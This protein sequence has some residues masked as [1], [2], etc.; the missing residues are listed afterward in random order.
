MILRVR[1]VSTGNVLDTVT[2]DGDAVAY[3]TGAARSIV[4]SRA[5]ARSRGSSPAEACTALCGWSNGYLIFEE[6]GD[7]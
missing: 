6:V 5:R 3:D 1:L 4:E 2:V 7:Q